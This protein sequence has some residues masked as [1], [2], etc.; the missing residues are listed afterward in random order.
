MS[1][2]TPAFQFLP[3][4]QRVVDEAAELKA[5]LNKLESFIIGPL[6]AKLSS[7]EQRLLMDQRGLMQSLH[8]VLEKRIQLF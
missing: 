5:R 4:Q 3:H 7:A 2:P 6:F 8:E 1:I